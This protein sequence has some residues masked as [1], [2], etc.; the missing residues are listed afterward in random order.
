METDVPQGSI[1]GPLLFTI[2]MITSSWQAKNFDSIKYA[3]DTNL[4]R[5]LC[6]LSSP[7]DIRTVDVVDLTSQKIKLGTK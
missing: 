5:P 2:Y 7:T 3:D 6:T 1:L 4:V